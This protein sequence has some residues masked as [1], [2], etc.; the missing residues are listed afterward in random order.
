LGIL[1]IVAALGLAFARD[2]YK[3]LLRP[4]DRRLLAGLALFL[5]VGAGSAAARSGPTWLIVNYVQLLPALLL[6]A[7]V[8]LFKPPSTSFYLGCIVGALGAGAYA[9]WQCEWLGLPRA[10][11]PEIPF[12]PHMS[13]IFGGLAVVLGLLPLFADP[14][15]LRKFGAWPV[16]AGLAGAMIAAALSGSRSA[17][18]AC[19]FLLLWHIARNK[20]RNALW[21]LT[22]IVA[23]S[24]ALPILSHR[25][26]EAYGNLVD[27]GNGQ[28]DTPLGL[29]FE[30][31]K[32]AAAAFASDPVF[33][34]GPRAFQGWLAMRAEQG[35]GPPTL[36]TFDH[37]HNDALHALAT[38]GL[39]SAAGW[40]AAFWLPWRYFWHAA[41]A[42]AAPAA[43]AGQALVAT[44]FMLGLF[45]T[46]LV[47]RVT[48]TAYVVGVVLLAG[49]TAESAHRE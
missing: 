30:M 17:W 10:Y 14:P 32:A 27:Y 46:L 18:L 11:G 34:I 47:H 49:W 12:G 37:A 1:A 35:F 7:A 23:I 24:F 38:G 26:H 33:G 16:L 21:S 4:D 5:L 48:L 19:I 3:E 43:R 41:Q 42:T 31:W 22:A 13:T 15:D 8:R 29:R 40:L 20:P 25:W 28:A 45:D 36:A 9:L 39:L 44:F 6:L 2:G